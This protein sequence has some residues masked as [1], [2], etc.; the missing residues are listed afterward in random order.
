MAKARRAF[1]LDASYTVREGR[2]YVSLLLKGRKLTRLYYQYDPYFYVEAPAGREADL[3]KVTARRKNGEVAQPIRVESAELAAG[4]DKKRLA[5]VF[6][7]MPQDVP[8][9]KS[10]MPYRC[11]EY[12][13]P[14]ARRF[15]FDFGLV[16]LGVVSYER[17]GHVI[18]RIRSVKPGPPDLNMLSFDIETYNPAGKPRE[19]QDPAIMISYCGRK[20]GVLTYK[21]CPKAFVEKTAGEREMLERFSGIVAEQDPDVLIGYNS[22]NFDIPYL[23]ARAAATKA[24]FSLCKGGS[25]PRKLKKGQVTGMRVPGRIHV[26]LY[27]I[28]RFYGFIGLVKAQRFTLDAVAKEVLGKKKVEL[29]KEEIWRRWDSGDI[30]ELA[31]YSLV[32]SELTMQLAERLLPIT[33]ELSGLT[34]MPLFDTALSTS[35]QLVENLLMAE[36]SRNRMLIPSKPGG[37]A[38]YERLNAPIQGAY[39]KLPEPGIYDNMA[40]LDFRGLYPSIIISYNIDPYTLAADGADGDFHESP[41]GARFLKDTKGLVPS[42]LERLVDLRAGLKDELKSLDKDSDGYA[43]MSARSHALKIVSNSFYGYLGYARSRWYSRQCAESVTAWG[44]K[45]IIDT[46]EKAEKTGFKVLYGDSLPYDRYIFIMDKSGAISHVKIGDFVGQNKKNPRIAD[47]KTLA[48]D[49]SEVVFR[50]I[51]RAI[52]HPYDSKSGNLLEFV[53]TH[54]RTVVTP[55]HSVYFFDESTKTVRLADAKSLRVGDNLIS[56]TNAPSTVIHRTGEKIDILDLDF[57][58]YND[59]LR[60]YTDNLR[61][62]ATRRGECPYCGKIRALHSH[63]SARHA[64]RKLRLVEAR[65]TGARFVGGSNAKAGR[66]P[67]FWRLSAELAWVMGYYAAEGSAS[68]RSPAHEKVMISFGSQDKETI[69]RVKRFFNR[70][71]GDDLQLIEDYDARIRRKMY[72]YRIQRLPLVALFKHGFGLGNRSDGKRVSP[73]I[74]S[75]EQKIRDAFLEGYLEG[76]GAKTK[77]PRYKTHFVRFSTKSKELAIGL[78]FLLKA[79]RHQANAFGSVM[80]HV[81]WLYRRD[82]PGIASLR[83]QGTRRPMEDFGNFCPARIKEIKKTDDTPASVFDL[84]VDGVHNFVD[85]EGMLLVHNTDSLFLLREN[86]TKED[87][88]DFMQQV[89]RSLPEKM[90]LELEGFYPRGVFVSKKGGQ[91][92]GA[93]KK[94]ALLGEDG[95]IKIRGFEL[96]RRDWSPIAKNT[97]RRVLEAILKDGSRDKAVKIVKDTVARLRDGN[98]EMDELAIST[99]INKDPRKYEVASPELSA[100]KKLI[101]RGDDVGQGSMI[102]YVITKNGK[103]IS[104]KAEP[105]G[106]AKDYDPDYYINNQVLPAV[107]K[108]LKELGYDEYGLK[109]G[110]RQKSLDNFF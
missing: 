55:Q 29:D 79:R 46:I 51:R 69:M 11:Y 8:A 23:L 110:G 4:Q 34:M 95:R 59:R 24:K 107:L 60:A 43:R 31:E 61:F 58:P 28:I 78:Q 56:L 7:G 5:K 97:Q 72:Y 32:D 35:G 75:S 53:T 87:V 15:I 92:R 80:K 40:V 76:D 37:D 10:A 84:E 65:R 91:E 67:R 96:V 12:N 90:E 41:T 64:D 26:D 13:I 62:P 52:E 45:H 48:F 98:V 17:E 99:Q 82:K 14:F 88:L 38:I 77:E 49:G 89:N 42:V 100:A 33:M 20:K 81:H 66:I 39:V 103:S 106:L 50:P 71:L 108:I 18:K 36:A 104:E 25:V 68:E 86:K 6:C 109:M 57:G 93:K 83:L 85:A 70:L 1:F 54:G 74:Y 3:M 44:R 105:L 63:I 22:S 101:E 94:Y 27:P 9:L 102:S 21:D 47:F 30:G 16:P 73:L 19:R 2:T